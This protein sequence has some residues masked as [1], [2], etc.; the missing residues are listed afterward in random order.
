MIK[1][2]LEMEGAIGEENA[3]TSR[4]IVETTHIAQRSLVAI[5]A[6]ERDGGALI[7]CKQGGKGGYYMPANDAEILAQKARLEKGFASR[8][9]AVKPFREWAKAHK[10]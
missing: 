2:L 9:R 8:A 4:Y 5:V 10:E 7:C 3:L 1:E 6:N